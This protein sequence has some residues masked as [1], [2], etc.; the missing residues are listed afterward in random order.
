VE[1]LAITVVGQ[2]VSNNLI[3]SEDK[4][5]YI[6]SFQILF[7]KLI[8]FT[9]ILLV[10]AKFELIIQTILFLCFFSNIR[11]HTGGFHLSGFSSCFFASVGL[12]LVYIKVIYD[13]FITYIEINYIFLVLALLIILCIGA[14]NNP[15]IN[16]TKREYRENSQIA[17]CV[18]IVEVFIIVI[19]HF[20]GM[21]TSYLLFMS[22]GVILS[23]FLLLIEKIY[24]KEVC[25]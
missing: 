17:K 18:A 21:N 12:Y 3:D 23:A 20:L 7:E 4:E 19:L 25:V 24:R 5:L 15:N 2:M 8:A 13:F 22:F 10:A 14:V 11:K 1:K 9:T 16:W 6:Y